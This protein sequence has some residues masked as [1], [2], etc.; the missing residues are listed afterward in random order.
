MYLCSHHTLPPVGWTLNC[1][2]PGSN[3]NRGKFEASDNCF[4]L[5]WL[6]ALGVSKGQS[7]QCQSRSGPDVGRTSSDVSLLRWQS[8]K[9]LL[10][11]RVA[12]GDTEHFTPWSPDHTITHTH[13]WL[14]TVCSAKL[15]A[16]TGLFP[17][18]LDA[19][20]LKG[21]TGYQ[22]ILLLMNLF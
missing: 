9:R 17:S 14:P 1:S 4:L 5:H 16:I 20:F 18:I 6:G 19:T 7:S 2:H 22:C 13:S 3:Y 10:P 21:H 8:C 11:A 12:F 15:T